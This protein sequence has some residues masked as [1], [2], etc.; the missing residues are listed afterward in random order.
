MTA[1]S[2]ALEAGEPDA[3]YARLQIFVF[4]AIC[5]LNQIALPSKRYGVREDPSPRRDPDTTIGFT[6]PGVSIL[7]LSRPRTADSLG[8]RL[9]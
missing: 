3:G 9:W 2:S 4:V 1:G 8:L 5:L 6:E 7:G